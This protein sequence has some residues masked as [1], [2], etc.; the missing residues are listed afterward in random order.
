MDSTMINQVRSFNRLVT[1]RVGALNDHFL[2]R[3]RP[4]GECRLLWEVPD[5]GIEVRELRRKL[6]LDSAYVSRLLRSLEHQGLVEVCDSPDDARVRRVTLTPAGSVERGELDRL[7]NDFAASVLDPLSP[8]QRTRLT[9]AMAEVERLLI[10]SMVEIA[11][12]DA[13]SSAVSWCFEQYFRELDERFEAGFDP[14]QSISAN[15]D[16]LTPPAGAV[17]VAR[18]RGEPVGC[19]ALKFHPGNPTELKR[20]WVHPSVRGIGLGKRLLTALETYAYERGSTT[21]HL[22]TNGTLTEAIALYRRS[23]YREVPAFNA[24]P[25]AQ[26]WFE[27]DLI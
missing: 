22:E 8:S 7:S 5:A 2:G 13:R 10:A 25:Y 12:D 14:G 24:E 6:G 16:E 15:A 27:K 11:P 20:M 18:L 17:L 19:G 1:E 26:H 3:D 23:G 9:A 4:L 21:I